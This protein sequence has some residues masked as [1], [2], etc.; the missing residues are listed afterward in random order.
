MLYLGSA[1]EHRPGQIRFVSLPLAASAAGIVADEAEQ[2]AAATAAANS[3]TKFICHGEPVMGLALAPTQDTLFSVGEDGSLAIIRPDP[4]DADEEVDAPAV[5]TS[6]RF[7]QDVLVKKEK[8]EESNKQ[9]EKLKKKVAELKMHNEYQLR[10]KDMH[11]DEKLG[12]LTKGFE[13][14]LA[15][16]AELQRALKEVKE[17]ATAKHLQTL[18][19]VREKHATD[20]EDMDASYKKKVELEK[21]RSN[22]LQKDK[23]KIQR[24]WEA[25]N[26]HLIQQHEK[27]VEQVIEE[28][29]GRLKSESM[30]RDNIAANK[31]T[32]E[33]GFNQQVHLMEEDARLEIEDLKRGFESKLVAEREAT[34]RLKGENILMKNKHERLL[35]D[36][37]GHKREIHEREITIRDKDRRIYDLKKK[38]QELEKFKFVLDYKIK[39]LKRQL[40]PRGE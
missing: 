18:A 23:A 35:Q 27:Y 34:L 10:L 17:V 9:T 26:H 28:Y 5:T 33:K 1:E 25:E 14:Q 36:I 31:L 39:E 12:K 24:D 8:I 29:E 2:L 22:Q 7:S 19:D 38:N 13:E 15:K 6:S 37:G 20:M 30:Q 3:G 21:A 4:E 40:N 11:H 32:R 16:E